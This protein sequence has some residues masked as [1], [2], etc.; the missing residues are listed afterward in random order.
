MF[1]LI[2]DKFIALFEESFKWLIHFVMSRNHLTVRINQPKQN[3]FCIRWHD[4]GLPTGSQ[5][6]DAEPPWGGVRQHHPP[7]PPPP[8]SSSPPS[9][10]T[11]RGVWGLRLLGPTTSSGPGDNKRHELSVLRWI[12]D[13]KVS[14]G[15]LLSP[16]K[17]YSQSQTS[18]LCC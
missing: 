6:D 5:W 12:T 4:L 9:R 18:N 3:V 7:Q 13:L 1:Y 14:V 15:P 8:P 16:V 11:P 17:S 10:R 2:L